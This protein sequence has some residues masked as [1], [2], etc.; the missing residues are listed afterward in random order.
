MQTILEDRDTVAQCH[1][2][3]IDNTL[4]I[5]RQELSI[6][7]QVEQP[8]GDVDM[9]VS[10]LSTLLQKRRQVRCVP[11]V[12]M[13]VVVDGPSHRN[14]TGNRRIGGEA[15]DIPAAFGGGGDA[16]P[17]HASVVRCNLAAVERTSV[18]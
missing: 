7:F 8:A 4:E 2:R 17:Y 18:L 13:V 12:V 10:K 11:C 14:V 9:Y 1:R 6:L 3:M 16:V 5:T 15:E